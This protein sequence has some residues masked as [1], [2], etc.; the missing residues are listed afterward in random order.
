M[1]TGPGFVKS[2]WLWEV[3][4]SLGQFIRIFSEKPNVFSY[5]CSES[6]MARTFM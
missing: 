3:K 5:V 1:E 2:V 6:R 4:S